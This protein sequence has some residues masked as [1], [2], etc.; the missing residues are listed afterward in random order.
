M[1]KS[2]PVAR[3][4]D[5]KR[6]LALAP[7]DALEMHVQHFSDLFDRRVRSLKTLM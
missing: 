5:L 7:L 4:V 6:E 1:V 3:D 2:T